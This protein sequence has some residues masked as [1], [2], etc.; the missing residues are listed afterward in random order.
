[1][2]GEC[3]S[4]GEFYSTRKQVEKEFKNQSIIA[5]SVISKKGKKRTT[6]VSI[7]EQ[8]CYYLLLYFICIVK[9]D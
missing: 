2:D 9:K 7:K 3:R 6:I 1:M 4:L 8:T 5:F